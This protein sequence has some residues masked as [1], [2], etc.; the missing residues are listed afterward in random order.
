MGL[1]AGTCSLCRETIADPNLSLPSVDILRG[2]TVWIF[3]SD[4]AAA[5]PFLEPTGA[6]SGLAGLGP[7]PDGPIAP[8]CIQAAKARV[9]AVL[10][11]LA[12]GGKICLPVTTGDSNHRKGTSHNPSGP[13]RPIESRICEPKH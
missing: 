7:M 11:S 1:A 3:H 13:D 5:S 4:A 8:S 12:R 2:D 6:Q 9:S 10:S